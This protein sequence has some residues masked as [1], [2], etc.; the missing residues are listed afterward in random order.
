MKLKVNIR[1]Q[2]TRRCGSEIDFPVTIRIDQVL[3]AAGIAHEHEFDIDI[4]ELLAQE[5][6]IAHVWGTDDVQ[7]VRPDLDDGQAWQVLQ[8]IDKRLDS[9]SG[10]CWETIEIVADELFGPKPE[11]RWHGRIDVTITDTDGYGQEEAL[12]RFRDMAGQLAK[13]MPDIKANADEGSVKL[14]GEGQP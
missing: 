2:L 6:K 4:H 13:D 14:A 5:R 12:T 11:R 1:E 7:E 9:E 10:I 3:K 8:T